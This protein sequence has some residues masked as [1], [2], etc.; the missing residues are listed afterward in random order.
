MKRIA[1]ICICVLL[2]ASCV[3]AVA[4]G[5]QNSREKLGE[6]LKSIDLSSLSY[7]ALLLLEQNIKMELRS[8]PE[9]GVFQ[10]PEQSYI[11]GRDIPEGRYCF[12]FQGERTI[13]NSTDHMGWLVLYDTYAHYESGYSYNS[14]RGGGNIVVLTDT[15]SAEVD[16]NTGNVLIVRVGPVAAERVGFIE[17]TNPY[18]PPTGT[19]I[20][21]GYYTIGVDIPAGKYTAFFRGVDDSL[22]RIYDS[23]EDHQNKNEKSRTT[24]DDNNPQ[25]MLNLQEGQI[26]DVYG[27]SVIM[28]KFEAFAFE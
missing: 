5:S 17:K 24:V 11:V 25:A 21:A 2:S 4:E 18:T 14:R 6:E 16:L 23:E 12:T 8:R 28:K 13:Y 15:D 3:P 22:L 1:I 26:L 7:D 10:L 19:E 27:G 9:G 20:P